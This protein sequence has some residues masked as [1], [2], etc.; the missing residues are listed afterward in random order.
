MDDNRLH[1]GILSV[2]ASNVAEAQ[3]A[4]EWGDDEIVL[5]D[6]DVDGH[7]CLYLLIC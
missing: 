2:V 6:D 3:R 4:V 7:A 5:D 1:A